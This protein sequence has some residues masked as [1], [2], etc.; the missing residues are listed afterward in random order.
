[1]DT[2]TDTC[3][4]SAPLLEN[5]L[6]ADRS[7]E[8]ITT[9]RKDFALGENL[10]MMSTRSVLLYQSELIDYSVSNMIHVDVAANRKYDMDTQVL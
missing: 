8:I 10:T 5:A 7:I 4:C 9:R 3:V 1:M 2:D 6:D